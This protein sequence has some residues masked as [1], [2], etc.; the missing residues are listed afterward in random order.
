MTGLRAYHDLLDCNKTQ[1]LFYFLIHIKT[2]DCKTRNGTK[3][4]IKKINDFYLVKLQT[5]IAKNSAFWFNQIRVLFEFC[6]QPQVLKS[7][8]FLMDILNLRCTRIQIFSLSTLSIW[9]AT[10]LQYLISVYD[11]LQNVHKS[12]I[13]WTVIRETQYWVF[14]VQKTHVSYLKLSFVLMMEF[15][16]TM[17]VF[18]KG[19]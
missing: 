10:L 19:L 9:I 6:S 7:G 3:H 5:L 17:Q 12:F 2:G 14:I 4:N 8:S 1:W 11:S 18:F 15:F 16:Y 13:M